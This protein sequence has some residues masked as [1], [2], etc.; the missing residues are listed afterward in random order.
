MRYHLY[1]LFDILAA[2][3]LIIADLGRA[4]LRID[5]GH[6]WRTTQDLGITAYRKIDDLEPV[7]RDSYD[8][9][10]LSLSPGRMRC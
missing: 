10:G 5:Y 1:R 4:F 7:Y 6:A 2:I 8:T 3:A 9:H